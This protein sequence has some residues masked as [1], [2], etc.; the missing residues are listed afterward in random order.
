MRSNYLNFVMTLFNVFG[1]Y[2]EDMRCFARHYCDLARGNKTAE[3]QVLLE[4]LDPKF[5]VYRQDM[6]RTIGDLYD[7]FYA[8]SNV[9]LAGH[10]ACNTYACDVSREE[11]QKYIRDI[12]K[13]V[14]PPSLDF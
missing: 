14:A 12:V 10:E 5:A 8:A 13:E 7:F 1:E 2:K 9:G 4:A 3:D 6:D 11:I